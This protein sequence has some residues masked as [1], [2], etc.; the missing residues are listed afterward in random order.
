MNQLNDEDK[1]DR[2]NFIINNKSLDAT[3][4]QVEKIINKIKFMIS[5]QS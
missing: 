3:K 1:I 2:S 4:L 5:S